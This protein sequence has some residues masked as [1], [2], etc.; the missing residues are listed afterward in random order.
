MNIGN[1]ADFDPTKWR[2]L[3]GL[4][5]RI[6]EYYA[7][8]E[9]STK[10]GLLASRV[11]NALDILRH[12]IVSIVASPVSLLTTFGITFPQ[13]HLLPKA[14]TLALIYS[15]SH[16]C[17]AISSLLFGTW[18]SAAKETLTIPITLFTTPLYATVSLAS[19]CLL[20]NNLLL[21]LAIPTVGRLVRSLEKVLIIEQVIEWAQKQVNL[22]EGTEKTLY[23][24]RWSLQSYGDLLAEGLSAYC[25]NAFADAWAQ[26]LNL[27][28]CAWRV[29]T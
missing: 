1:C 25:I 26:S 15:V 3:S 12:A 18:K 28:E 8:D 22:L 10:R 4:A 11:P 29:F 24:R 14:C 5:I 23:E 7:S 27:K 13:L 2:Y 19:F 9:D 16:A 17:L 21:G 20:K 6:E